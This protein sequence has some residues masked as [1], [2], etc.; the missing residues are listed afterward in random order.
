M[1]GVASASGERVRTAQ[2]FRV[3]PA[4]EPQP[5][6]TW[7]TASRVPV[8]PSLA[9]YLM[10]VCGSASMEGGGPL[11]RRD[12]FTKTPW[13]GGQRKYTLSWT[14]PL[15]FPVGAEKLC[16]LLKYR[17]NDLHRMMM[18]EPQPCGP[19]QTLND[20]Q[21]GLL[22]SCC[23]L[24]CRT[25]NLILRFKDQYSIVHMDSTANPLCFFSLSLSTCLFV[26]SQTYETIVHCH[27]LAHEKITQ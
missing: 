20:G 5:S 14:V 17:T 8:V 6:R 3:Q 11:V 23:S 16:D 19:H 25:L 4:A 7:K 2:G 9:S 24:T 18:R 27:R 1:H 15:C 22:L 26:T 13:P 21:Q 10:R 12:G